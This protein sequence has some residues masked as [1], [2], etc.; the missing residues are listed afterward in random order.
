MQSIRVH[1]IMKDVHRTKY[2]IAV[3][4]IVGSSSLQLVVVSSNLYRKK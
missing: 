2:E 1:V 3:T 4:Y